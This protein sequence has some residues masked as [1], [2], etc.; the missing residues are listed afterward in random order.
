MKEEKEKLKCDWL[1]ELGQ[2]S[3]KPEMKNHTLTLDSENSY[4]DFC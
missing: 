2:T 1:I 4:V 3:G